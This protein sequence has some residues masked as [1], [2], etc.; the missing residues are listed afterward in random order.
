LIPGSSFDEIEDC[1]KRFG[2]TT[3]KKYTL[4]DC[5]YY[6]KF[7]RGQLG[8][9]LSH[10]SIW[11]SIVSDD[12]AH[13]IMEDDCKIEPRLGTDESSSSFQSDVSNV[14]SELPPDF[15][16][17]YLYVYHDHYKNTPDVTIEGK[18]YINR[19]LNK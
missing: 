14:L 19:L 4:P 6:F 11:H 1:V 13:V 7:T 5:K 17:C 12:K 8:C 9:A 2:L 10:I 3:N 18:E 15:D 16:M